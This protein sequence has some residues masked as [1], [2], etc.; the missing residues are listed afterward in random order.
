M[1][2]QQSGLLQYWRAQYTPKAYRCLAQLKTLRPDTK[3]DKLTLDFL[4]SAFLLYGIGVT[5]SVLMFVIEFGLAHLGSRKA[6]ETK[7]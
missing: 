2:M 6:S 1:I 7:V 3:S 5:I 4:S